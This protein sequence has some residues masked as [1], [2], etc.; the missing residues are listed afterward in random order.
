MTINTAIPMVPVSDIVEDICG[1]SEMKISE[2]LR[3]VV[4]T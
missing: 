1:L 2:D 3:F 4:E